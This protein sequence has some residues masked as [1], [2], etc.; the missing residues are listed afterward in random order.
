VPV[1]AGRR[2]RAP[3]QHGAVFADPPLAEA[4]R[5]LAAPAAFPDVPIAGR[6]LLELRGVAARSAFAAAQSYLTEAGQPYPSTF[7]GRILAAGHQP[8]LFH[9]GVWVKNFAL[10]GL[11]RSAGLTP[12]NLIVDN[13]TAKS[14]YLMLPA[15]SAESAA[16]A[17]SYHLAK[18]PYDEGPGEVPHE[19]CPVHDEQLFA[20]LV[21]RAAVWTRAWPFQPL[22]GDYWSEVLR[23]RQRTPL[24][25]ER[26]VAGRRALE[27]RWGCQNLEVP[28]SR[29]CETEAFAWFAAHLF[30]EARRFHTIYNEAVHEYRRVH[31]LRSRNHPVPDLDADGKWLELPL[32]AWRAGARRRGRLMVKPAADGFELRVAGET[33]PRLPQGGAAFAAAWQALAR[34]G[35]K[36]RSRALTN[37]LYTRLLV[38]DNFLHGIGGG[39]YDELTDVLLLRFFGVQAPRFLVLSATLL[40]PLTTFDI[41]VDQERRLR[42]LLRDLQWNPQRHL[43]PET[44]GTALARARAR[45]ELLDRDPLS[46]PVGRERHLAL[47]H[48]TAELQ[49]L[50]ADVAVQRQA[51]LERVQAQLRANAVMRRRDFA[52]CLYPAELLRPFC[53][54]FLNPLTVA[55]SAR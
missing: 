50:V 40:L 29:L 25:G 15:W 10:H 20:T 16:D 33:W 31:R 23:H 42:N 17:A 51:E 5:L 46:P 26:L 55:A 53:E 18:I 22:L 13:D 9:P 6:S 11:A 48:L 4:V 14:S 49:P 43:P 45:A 7:S 30:A 34:D 47:R 19:V 35:F 54:Q 1:I 27:R 32:W 37:T 39:K 36:I 2:L 21:E 8:E 12:L 44:S 24:V 38:A 28:V 3:Q 41:T 52:F